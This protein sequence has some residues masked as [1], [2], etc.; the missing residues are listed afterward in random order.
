MKET[1][2][3]LEKYQ[4]AEDKFFTD[5]S[6][7]LFN[8]DGMTIVQSAE[9]HNLECR[10]KVEIIKE[11]RTL[12]ETDLEK[13]FNPNTSAYGKYINDSMGQDGLLKIRKWFEN[14]IKT[15]GNKPVTWEIQNAFA[16]VCSK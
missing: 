11:T 3:F 8:W 4:E 15:N 7:P 16:I 5:S 13:W 6:N 14:Y 9:Q 12:R 2:A 1:E 10:I